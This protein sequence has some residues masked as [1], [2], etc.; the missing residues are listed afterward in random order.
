MKNKLRYTFQLLIFACSLLFLQSCIDATKPSNNPQP[1][2]NAERKNNLSYGA[3]QRHVMDVYLPEKRDSNTPFIILIHGGAWVAGDKGDMKILQDSLL[4][5]GIASASINYRYVN[6]TLH[7]EA[8][9]ADVQQAINFCVSK[10]SE[11]NIRDNKYMIAGAS[12]GG[13]MAMLYGYAYDNEDRIGG[14]ISAA[15]PTDMT[16][17]D[18]LNYSAIIGLIDEIQYMVGATYQIFQPLPARFAQS[19]P[20]HNISNVPTLLLHGTADAVVPVAHSQ[21]IKAVLDGQGIA[22]KLVTFNEAGHDLGLA[23]AANLQKLVNEIDAWCKLYG[24]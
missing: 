21:N 6:G 11:W 18:Y 7:C 16:N 19:S 12:A 3:D 20:L 9:M 24:R 17:I 23:N 14:I 1:S 15:G 22:N 10:K 13:H 5:K 8:L 2:V 4:N